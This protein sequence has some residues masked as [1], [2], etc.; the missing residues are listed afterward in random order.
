MENNVKTIL[1]TEDDF[2]LID[3]VKLKLKH[4]GFNVLSSRTVEE[5]LEI[6]NKQKVDLVWTDHYLLGKQNGL[7]FVT[8]IKNNPAL[9]DTPVIVVSQTSTDDTVLK[10]KQLGV[11]RFYTKMDANLDEV[12]DNVKQLLTSGQKSQ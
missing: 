3:V 10:Y 11:A 12:I 1:F 4:A 5:S 2:A 8:Q 6:L 9:K 7:D